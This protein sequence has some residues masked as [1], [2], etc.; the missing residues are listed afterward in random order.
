MFASTRVGVGKFNAR[1]FCGLVVHL[2]ER[3]ILRT[4]FA[5]GR[6]A[7]HVLVVLVAAQQKPQGQLGTSDAGDAGLCRSHVESVWNMGLRWLG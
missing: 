6:T 2:W 1:R 3:A 4:L 5:V 7:L